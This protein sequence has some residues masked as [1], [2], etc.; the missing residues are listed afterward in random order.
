MGFLAPRRHSRCSARAGAWAAGT[1]TAGDANS[2]PN[3]TGPSP[4][5]HWPRTCRAAPGRSSTSSFRPRRPGRP[6]A[7]QPY[8]GFDRGSYVDFW[9][10]V[11]GWRD[12]G[13]A[14]VGAGGRCLDQLDQV[15]QVLDLAPG[16]RRRPD[17]PDLRMAGS[18]LRELLR[19]RRV[20]GLLLLVPLVLYLGRHDQ[21]GQA[22]RFA[23]WAWGSRSARRPSRPS[24]AGRSSPDS[25]SPAFGPASVPG[26][27]ARPPH[28]RTPD[29]RAVLRGRGRGPGCGEPAG[30]RHGTGTDHPGGGP[31]GLLLGLAVPGTWRA[32]CC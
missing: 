9:Q 18:T 31:L 19:R 17:D 6:V 14:I 32:P 30:D 16:S 28:R 5:A 21:P 29:L 26:P 15:D 25:P 12:P 8:Q 1:P 24:A 3:S 11:W 2:P 22:I 20:L 7:R 13:K 23:S 10:N 4:A 27:S